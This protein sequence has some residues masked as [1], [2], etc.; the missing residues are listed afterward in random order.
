MSLRCPRDRPRRDP[1]RRCRPRCV[2]VAAVP[3]GLPARAALLIVAFALVAAG[4]RCRTRC[5]RCGCSCWPTASLAGDGTRWS[6]SPRRR[7]PCSAAATWFLRDRS[8]P[9]DPAVPRPGD[10]RAGDPRRRPAGRRSPSIEHHERPDYLDRLAVLRDQVFVLDHMYLSVFSTCGLV[11]RLVVTVRPARV[12]PS[13]CCCCWCCS[14]CRR[15]SARRGARRSSGGSRRRRARHAPPGRAPV[16]DGHHRGAGQGG[17][18]HRHRRR[19][20]SRRRRSEWERWYAPVAPR[21]LGQR[22]VAHARPGR[23]S[24][25]ATSAP[26]SSSRR[27]RR[28]GR[29]RAAD[30]RRRRPAVGL[31]RRH[32]GRDRL[33]ARDLAGR[34]APAGLAR[35]L[36]RRAHVADADRPAPERLARGHPLRARVV[37]LSRAPT[38][39]CSTTSTSSCRPARWSRSSARTA[40]ASRP[41]SSCCASCTSRPR[42]GSWSTASRWPGSPADEWRE[43]AGRRA[44]RTSSGSSSWPGTSVGR[45]R[46]AAPGRRR[47][48]AAPRSAGPA[49]TTSSHG[50]R[51]RPRHPAR[52]DLAR[53][54]SRCQLRPVAEARPGPGLHAR[55]AA[56]AG[57]RRA[58]RG[59]RRRD[60]ARAVRALRRRRPAAGAEDG[61]VTVLVSHRFSTVRMA[62]LIV[63]LDGSRLARSAPTTS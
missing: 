60:R 61:R 26:S 30:P 34:L 47:R 8:T 43:R 7:W 62:D 15:C 17:P 16:R 29:R 5:S 19:R 37:P 63:V 31:R 28:V 51:A 48:R 55:R 36:R 25:S 52:P 33:P 57:A 42:A 59:A 38:G 23:S 49:P 20:W 27:A 35:G 3:L 13:R 24:G 18:G 11:L 44:S 39:W 40:P 53:R 41:W 50:C 4:R 6:W 58:D 22:G 9:G 54:A 12:D 21:P 32:R 45:R 56:A 14:R 10:D 1:R 46:P 2:D